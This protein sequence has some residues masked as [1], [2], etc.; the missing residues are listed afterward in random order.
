[1]KEWA[2]EGE[3]K[4]SDQSSIRRELPLQSRGSDSFLMRDRIFPINKVAPQDY[5]SCPCMKLIQGQD[6]LLQKSS[7]CKTL[8]WPY[9]ARRI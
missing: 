9:M 6:F 4:W 2:F 5:N 1:M 7:L 3:A 8:W